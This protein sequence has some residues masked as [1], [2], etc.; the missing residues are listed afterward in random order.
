MRLDRGTSGMEWGPFPARSS[1]SSAASVIVHISQA[2]VQTTGALQR[3][4]KFLGSWRIPKRFLQPKKTHC[5]LLLGFGFFPSPLSMDWKL[6]MPE[7][8]FY[9]FRFFVWLAFWFCFLVCLVL[10]FSRVKILTSLC[11][12]H[13]F[14]LSSSLS[15]SGLILFDIFLCV[16]VCVVHVNS[17]R[18][19]TRSA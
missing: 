6:R 12:C 2:E 3:K 10:F 1:L 18:L 5:I 7:S 13:F 15:P 9:V 4:R 17:F 8:R 11:S 14:L 16:C 19:C